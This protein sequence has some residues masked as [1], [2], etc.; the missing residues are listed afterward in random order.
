MKLFVTE[1]TR[2]FKDFKSIID[3]VIFNDCTIT[4]QVDQDY[5]MSDHSIENIQTQNICEVKFSETKSFRKQMHCVDN[6]KIHKYWEYSLT[7]VNRK[8]EIFANNV[9]SSIDNTSPLNE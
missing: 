9:L 2:I 8:R 7:D 1:Y 5:I 4:S 6:S 3:L